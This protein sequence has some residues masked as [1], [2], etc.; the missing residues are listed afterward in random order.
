MNRHRKIPSRRGIFDILII[1]KVM[2]CFGGNTYSISTLRLWLG[3][4]FL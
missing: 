2:L 4:A 3:M 1:L